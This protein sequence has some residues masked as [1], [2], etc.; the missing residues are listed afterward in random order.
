MPIGMKIE[1]ANI[2][3]FLSP[4]ENGGYFRYTAPCTI[5]NSAFA[6]DE[7]AEVRI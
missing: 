6:R 5:Y 4:L 3:G 2:E 1:E 7:E